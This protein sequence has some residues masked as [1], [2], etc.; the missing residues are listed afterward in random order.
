M[1]RLIISLV[2]IFLLTGCSGLNAYYDYDGSVNFK[3]YKSYFFIGWGE[4]TDKRL[5][6]FEKQRY[7][8][9][10]QK[11][12][13]KLGF[14]L[15]GSA[16]EAD[17]VMSLVYNLDKRLRT[18]TNGTGYGGYRYDGWGAGVR[19]YSQTSYTYS[20]LHGTLYCD[21]Y[22]QKMKKLVWQG[23]VTGI[24]SPDPQKRKEIIPTAVK[25][26]M[27]QYPPGKED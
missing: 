25:K 15:A 12:M 26:M 19:S 11:E 24:T 1:F 21:L 10:V 4:E 3:P 9:A 27:M 18:R 13:R 8:G 23:F 5:S 2:F 20:Y 6:D 17:L 14:E 16:E 22:D 7:E